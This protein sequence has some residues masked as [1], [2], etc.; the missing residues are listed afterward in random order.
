MSKLWVSKSTVASSLKRSYFVCFYV[1]TNGC[2]STSFVHAEM[3]LW[4]L[5]DWHIPSLT[6][7]CTRC[8]NSGFG[9]KDLSLLVLFPL[10]QGDFPGSHVLW[11]LKLGFPCSHWL[12][13]VYIADLSHT[14]R[15]LVSVNLTEGQHA[16]PSDSGA[17]RETFPHMHCAQS[18]LWSRC[19]WSKVP[20]GN[21]WNCLNS[22]PFV[23]VESLRSWT[24]A[25]TDGFTCR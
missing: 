2:C 21:V 24:L 23:I 8:R 25:E 5:S 22:G 19:F 14:L 16:L 13:R 15:P 11:C 12:P 18:P 4:L 9:Q 1:N 3:L 10:A 7:L 17:S 20:Q 6:V